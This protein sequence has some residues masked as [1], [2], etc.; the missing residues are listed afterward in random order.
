MIVLQLI[1]A[2]I[3]IVLLLLLAEA[4]MRTI[5]GSNKMERDIDDL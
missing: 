3:S 2:L 1:G 4:S 5:S